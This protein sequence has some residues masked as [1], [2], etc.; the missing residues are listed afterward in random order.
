MNA[1]TLV[2]MSLLKSGYCICG[3]IILFG[4]WH[5]LWDIYKM[6]VSNEYWECV[7]EFSGEGFSLSYKLANTL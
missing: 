7:K 4:C 3:P 2:S 1:L 6:K 5:L